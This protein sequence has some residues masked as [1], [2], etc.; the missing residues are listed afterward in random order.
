MKLDFILPEVD[1]VSVPSETVLNETQ[2]QLRAILDFWGE[3]GERH[4]IGC[5]RKDGRL[6]AMLA[7]HRLIWNSD[8]LPWAKR[9]AMG[10][11][12]RFMEEAAAEMGFE[13][14]IDAGG[15][16]NIARCSDRGFDNARR[17]VLRAIELAA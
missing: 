7:N 15:L 12:E 16:S 10:L 3:N 17:M 6:C 2:Q 1:K 11:T 5:D 13:P 8:R 14:S 9:V 4:N